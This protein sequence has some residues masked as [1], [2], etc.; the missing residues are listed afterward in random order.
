MRDYSNVQSVRP[1]DEA[2]ATALEVVRIE[3]SR[4]VMPLVGPLLDAWDQVP[5]ALK[6][7]LRL[8]GLGRHLDLIEA[9]AGCEREE[10]AHGLR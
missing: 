4:A 7:Q 3:Q 8:I 10:V 9:M 5:V 2:I 6:A 1:C